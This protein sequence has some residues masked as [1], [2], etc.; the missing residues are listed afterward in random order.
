[1]EREQFLKFDGIAIIDS[2]SAVGDKQTLSPLS[3]TWIVFVS[4]F[5]FGNFLS[6]KPLDSTH[7]VGGKQTLS[8]EPIQTNYHWWGIETKV[9][10]FNHPWLF[11]I[12]QIMMWRE[13]L[14]SSWN[15]M[16]RTALIQKT[17]K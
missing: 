2:T 11:S 6:A 1:M 13:I 5:V 3:Y 9:K 14:I 7:A 10:V 16:V 15:L 8:P 4:I 17:D 12:W